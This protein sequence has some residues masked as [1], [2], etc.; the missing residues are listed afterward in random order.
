MRVSTQKAAAFALHII[1]KVL[2]LILD[3][4]NTQISYHLFSET[5]RT[6]SAPSG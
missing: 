4:T 1:K 6:V 5:L 2:H 3:E